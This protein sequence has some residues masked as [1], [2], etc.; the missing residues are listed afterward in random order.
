[1]PHLRFAG[2]VQLSIPV[3]VIPVI[4]LS[5]LTDWIWPTIGVESTH[6]SNGYAIK[7]FLTLGVVF[8][9]SAMMGLSFPL[10]VA[11]VLR[12]NR[13]ELGRSGI[14]LYAIN[15]LGGFSGIARAKGTEYSS[16]GMTS[17][18]VF[19]FASKVKVKQQTRKKQKHSLLQKTHPRYV[20]Y[21]F[22]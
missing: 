13:G 9:P 11:G 12:L 4:Y 16:N 8:P 15:T 3:L 21:T 20:I 7:S 5:G 17:L 19:A 10:I 6:G 2:W 18:A 14:N 1:M 22:A